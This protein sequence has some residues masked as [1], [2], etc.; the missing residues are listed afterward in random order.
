MKIWKDEKSREKKVSND[1]AGENGDNNRKPMTEN[2]LFA[3]TIG[4]GVNM[5]TII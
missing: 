2:S 5:D 3:I 1:K 4:T